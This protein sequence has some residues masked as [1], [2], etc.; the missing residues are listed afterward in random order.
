MSLLD[1][2]VERRGIRS[3]TY[4][5][6]D[7]KLGFG[8]EVSRGGGGVQSFVQ[9]GS[10]FIPTILSLLFSSVLSIENVS[11]GA[12]DVDFELRQPRTHDPLVCAATLMML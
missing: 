8:L 12:S 4:T 11:I 6:L 2:E 3:E 10:P 9:G 7:R 5:R 1:R